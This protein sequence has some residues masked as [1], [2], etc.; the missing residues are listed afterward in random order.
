MRAEA[1][2]DSLGALRP[3]F[4]HSGTVTAGSASQLSDGACAVVV[5]NKAVAERRGLRWL[6]EITGHGFVARPDS[7]LQSHPAE[8]IKAARSA[9]GLTPAELDL[10]EINEAFAAVGIASTR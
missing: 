9:A 7:T 1:S 5:M 10:V 6:A 4:H 3:A 2:V 8:A